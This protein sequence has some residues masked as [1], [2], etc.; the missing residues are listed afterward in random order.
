[1]TRAESL[2][3]LVL[4]RRVLPDPRHRGPTNLML[5]TLLMPPGAVVLGV[6]VLGERLT[7]AAV[8]GMVVIGGGLA[9]IDGRAVRFFGHFLGARGVGRSGRGAR[10]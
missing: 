8:V 7:I 5:V 4:I 6:V 3:L 2:L 9:L 1:M 10:L